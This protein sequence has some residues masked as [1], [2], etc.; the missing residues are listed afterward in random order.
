LNLDNQLDLSLQ[1]HRNL[2]QQ[3]EFKEGIQAFLEKR[4][5]VWDL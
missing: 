4:P 5:P 1:W 3:N 2:R